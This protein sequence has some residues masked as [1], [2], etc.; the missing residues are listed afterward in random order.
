VNLAQGVAGQLVVVTGPSGVGKGAVVQRVLAAIDDAR[1]SV[2][3]TTRE[4]R[5]GEVDGVD[6][7]FV[8][9]ARFE[10]MVNEGALLEW[11]EYAGNL[12]GTPADP[13]DDA[14]DDGAVVILEIEVKGA[15]QVRQNR[16]DALLVFLQPPSME[17]LERRLRGR[18]TESELDVRRR[19][20]VARIEMK[21]AGTFDAL[22]VNDD[23]DECTD[24]LVRIIRRARSATGS[25][26]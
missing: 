20:K 12:Y 15:L 4:P 2:S 25:S 18:G 3:V 22:L 6:Y 24:Q 19:L 10:Q 8:D 17:E 1:R 21:S 5:P 26:A 11:A 9:P 14:V 16:E 7:H 13:V 23:L